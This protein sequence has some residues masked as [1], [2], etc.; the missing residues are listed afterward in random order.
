MHM[1]VG[2]RKWQ[3]VLARDRRSDGA[4]VYAVRST[5]IYCRPSCPSRRP[6]REQ[7]VFFDA[8]ALAERE[9][10]RACRRCRPGER[11]DAHA[12]ALTKRVCAAIDASPD[13]PPSLRALATSSRV[14][15]YHLLRTFKRT[16]GIT[17]REYAEARRMN[18]LRGR[19]RSGASI[20]H[21]LYDTGF[22][23]SSR[24]YERAP[25]QLGMTPAAY[26]NGGVNERVSFT[27]AD[28]PLGRLLV[29]ATERGVCMVSLGDEDSALERVLHAELPAAEL[30]RDDD[31]LTARVGAIVD[32]LRGEEPHLDLPLDIRATAFQRRVWQ[33]LREIPYGATR[34]YAEV[35]RAIG[36][37]TAHRAVA[38]ACATNPV[39]LVIP[40]HRVVRSDGEMG[41][42]RLGAGRKKLLLEME[43]NR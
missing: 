12:L 20:T 25:A 37:P 34:T 32:Y 31:A 10:F 24:L 29:A 8:P 36:T 43:K 28:S 5:R 16:M 30:E 1:M 14:S 11:S 40:C 21:A 4:F 42:Y 33:A 23:S 13:S 3:A 38:R 41:G 22:S 27:I 9:G 26:R 6:K 7:V 39:P 2:D 19:L 18:R 35:A 15:P 17:P